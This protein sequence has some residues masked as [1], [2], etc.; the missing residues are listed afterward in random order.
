MSE[1]EK[2]VQKLGLP[3]TDRYDLPTSQSRF[4]DGANYRIEIS[5]IERPNVLNALIDEMEKRDVPVHRI[6]GVVMGGMLLSEEE[7][8]EFARAAKSAKLEVILGVGP[9]SV[10]DI[11]AQARTPEG[12]TAGLRIRGADQLMNAVKDVKR[13]V[14]C[15]IRGFLVFDEGLLWVL[16]ELRKAGAIPKKTVFKVSIFAG[17]ANPAAI[18][19]LEGLGANTVNPVADLS[20]P[21]IASLRSVTSIPLDIFVSIFDSFGGFVRFYEAP[22]IARIASP[23]YFKI[24]PGLAAAQYYKSYTSPQMLADLAREKVRQAQ[25]VIEFVEKYYKEAKLSKLGVKDLAIP[26]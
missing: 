22:E 8:R 9:R 15:G 12:I 24:E 5:G 13:A 1:I 6:I 17:H 25:V 7:L 21:Q 14:D 3:V 11:G 18:K 26:E 19:V 20:L 2:A 4:S 23:V 16:N 10:Y